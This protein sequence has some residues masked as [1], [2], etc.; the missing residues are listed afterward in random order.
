MYA[1]EF[2]GCADDFLTTNRTLLDK[3]REGATLVGKET[4]AS[5]RRSCVHASKQSM[6]VFD[7]GNS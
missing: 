2:R 4:S 6:N 3:P 5:Y 7:V 1:A